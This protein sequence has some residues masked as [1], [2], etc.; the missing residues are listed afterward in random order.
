MRDPDAADRAAEAL[1][2]YRESG[3]TFPEIAR[4][5]G[6][7]S[8]ARARHAVYRALAAIVRPEAEEL[9]WLM[10]ERYEVVSSELMRTIVAPPPK[11]EVGKI[12]RDEHGRPVAPRP[13]QRSGSRRLVRRVLPDP[14]GPRAPHAGLPDTPSRRHLLTCGF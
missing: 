13:M 7:A 1:R 3:L 4:T 6:Y 5:V 8:E 10:D 12:V 9:R 14:N 2:L 11:T